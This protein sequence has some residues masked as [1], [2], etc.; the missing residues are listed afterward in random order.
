M[1]MK[2]KDV[3]SLKFIILAFDYLPGAQ[4]VTWLSFSCFLN[5]MVV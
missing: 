3:V 5:R 2:F 1:S 4:V